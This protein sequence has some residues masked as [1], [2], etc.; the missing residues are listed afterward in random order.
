MT[1]LRG[2]L[3]QP[4]GSLTFARPAFPFTCSTRM[5]QAPLGSR[6]E[7]GHPVADSLVDLGRVAEKAASQVPASGQGAELQAE[8]VWT[9]V[10]L[11]RRTYGV[12]AR[13]LVD[14]R[15]HRASTQPDQPLERRPDR[16]NLGQF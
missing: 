4:Q 10:G 1:V 5:E 2:E 12:G 15:E 7:L 8:T 13:T 6:P 11:D 9:V 3:L 16:L 14:P